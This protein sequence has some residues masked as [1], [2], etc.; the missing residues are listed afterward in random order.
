MC[1]LENLYNESLSAVHA[2]SELINWFDP[3]HTWL[4]ALSIFLPPNKA[5][6]KMALKD[7]ENVALTVSGSKVN[8][9]CFADNSDIMA[10]SS[11]KLHGR[12]S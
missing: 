11:Q 3:H 4:L 10:E 6:V 12:H 7:K 2:D 1:I 9:L 5:V 8:N